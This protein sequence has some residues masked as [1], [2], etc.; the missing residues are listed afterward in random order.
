MRIHPN[1]R[2]IRAL[3]IAESFR[4]TDRMSTL[5]GVV[6]RSDMLLDGFVFGSA[7][8]GGDDATQALVRMFRALRREDVNLIM[9]S[10][11]VISYYNVVDIDALSSKTG[12]PVVCLTYRE[13]TGIEDAIRSRFEDWEPKV[14]LYRRLGDRTTLNLR[15]GKRVFARLSSIDVEDARRVVD[16]FTLQGALAEPVRVA[17]LLARA[18]HADY[19]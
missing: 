9:L 13:S 14:S 3:G 7:K 12:V 5:A 17:R 16:S 8:V 11:A 2:G 19:R 18:R 4:R 6:M 15:T 1:K 10:G